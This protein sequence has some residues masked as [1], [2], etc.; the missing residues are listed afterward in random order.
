VAGGLVFT[1]ISVGAFSCGITSDGDGWCW[2]INTFGQLG[3]ESVRTSEVPVR[4]AGGLKFLSISTSLR[5]TCGITTDRRAWCWGENLVIPDTSTTT[6]LPGGGI[7]VSVQLF[8]GRYERRPT[9]VAATMRFNAIAAADRY[10]CALAVDDT[11]WC[12]GGNDD[13][14]LGDGT[15]IDRALPVR[16]VGEQRFKRLATSIASRHSCAIAIDGGAY[17]W[18][19]N[20]EG[21][22]GDGSTTESPRPV[23]VKGGLKFV[24]ISAGRGH[25]CAVTVDDAVW[26]WGARLADGVGTGAKP[27]SMVPVRVAQ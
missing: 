4:V 10:V 18:G 1:T 14:Q 2:G 12:W 8:G 9:A 21:Q 15:K 25:T 5:H 11:V 13:G 6:H 3:D 24:S 22:L 19:F 17:C 23:A 27:G 7:A 26:C 20:A 16:V